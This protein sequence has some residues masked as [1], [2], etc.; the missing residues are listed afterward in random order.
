MDEYEF[1]FWQRDAANVEGM[2]SLI[3]PRQNGRG[4][5]A[6][7]RQS[8]RLE[9]GGQFTVQR[10]LSAQPR[11]IKGHSRKLLPDLEMASEVTG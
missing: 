1:S 8:S 5:K 7:V 10:R 11:L 3:P 2:Q 4:A 9:R 6:P